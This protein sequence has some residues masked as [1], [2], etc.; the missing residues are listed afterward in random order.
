[1]SVLPVIFPAQ[2]FFKISIFTL[3]FQIT[4]LV[5]FRLHG[6]EG[7]PIISW[8]V[9]C[10]SSMIRIPTNSRYVLTNL[11]EDTRLK[12]TINLQNISIFWIMVCVRKKE[13][14]WKHFNPIQSNIEVIVS[15]EAVDTMDL[16]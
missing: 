9:N 11:D 12:H 10:R 14:L 16:A 4:S 6:T 5:C 7:T 13:T 8:G 3:Y 1:M 15:T 2:L